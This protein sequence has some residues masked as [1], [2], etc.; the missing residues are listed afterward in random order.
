MGRNYNPKS[1]ENLVPPWTKGDPRA[2]EAQ[3]L[4]RESPKLAQTLKIKQIIREYL[5]MKRGGKTEKELVFGKALIDKAKQGDVKAMEFIASQIGEMPE[6]YKAEAEEGEA[7]KAIGEGVRTI[8]KI[9]AFLNWQ[10]ERGNLCFLYGTTRSGKTYAVCQWLCHQLATGGI[11]GQIL[12]A[13]Q[14][15]PFLR[16]G[17]AAY[18]QTIAP[19]YGLEV[20]DNGMRVRGEHGL[21]V[22]QSFEKP[23]RVLSAQW[24]AVYINEGNVIPENIIDGLKIRCAGLLFSDFNPSC[25]EWWGKELMT[26]EN[27]LFCTFRDNP[28]LGERQLAAIETIRERGENAPLGSYANW[29]YQVYYL[30]RFSEMGGGVFTNVV[31]S[32]LMAWEAVALPTFWGIDFGDTSDPNAL[33]AVKVDKDGRAVHVL[34]QYYKTG[35][36]DLT[37]VEILKQRGVESLVFETATGGNTR[38][39]NFRAL[40]F[41]GNL[42]PCSKEQ[43]AQSVFNLSTWKIVCHDNVTADEF[44][45]YRLD[46][47]KFKGADHCIDATRYVTGLIFTNK[48]MA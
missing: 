47:G 45:C 38:A 41:T 21:I 22:L 8:A 36:D 32:N 46:G 18:L 20:Q 10:K 25:A 37:M 23:E 6:N 12:I 24:S 7:P 43:V 2:V 15:V 28:F 39:K 26:G 17:C 30:G 34:C 31:A 42:Y 9:H 14:T 29:Y 4:S 35:T 33:V 13:G 44:R 3:R 27:S 11:S 48:I 5:K 16:N 1:R 19:Q 40:G